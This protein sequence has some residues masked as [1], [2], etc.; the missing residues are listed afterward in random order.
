[1]KRLYVP[2]YLTDP[3]IVT[4]DPTQEPEDMPS[5]S[6][7]RRLNN[8]GRNPARSRTMVVRKPRV[9]RA[10]VSRGTP[11]GYYEIPV[12]VYH[13]CY[14]NSSTGIWPTDAITGVQTGSTGY[15]G[16]GLCSDLDSTFINF[17]NGGVAAQQIDAVPGFAQMQNVFD[18]VK[19]ARIHYEMWVAGTAGELGTTLKAALNI[20]VAVDTNNADGP[21]NLNEILQYSPVHTVKGDIGHTLRLTVYPKVRMSV[22]AGEQEVFTSTTL[23]SVQNAGYMEIAKPGVTHFGLRGYF[24]TT[25]ALASAQLGYLCIKE[26]QIR[27]YKVNK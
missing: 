22:G 23:A 13:R 16:F 6:Q 1:M 9:P 15:N 20:F 26:T 4:Q 18:E 7:R 12:T 5:R 21:S 14:F 2:S 19:I 11:D 24:E 17:G 27:R 10:I 25:S 8:Y 3:N